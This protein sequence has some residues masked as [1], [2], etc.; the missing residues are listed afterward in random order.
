VP[1]EAERPGPGGNALPL[2]TAGMLAVL[3][4]VDMVLIAMMNLSKN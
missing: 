3:L 1:A 4:I 2:P